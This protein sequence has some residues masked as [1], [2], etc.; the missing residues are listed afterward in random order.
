MTSGPDLSGARGAGRSGDG[1]GLSATGAGTSGDERSDGG[2][3]DID[4]SGIEASG[5]GEAPHRFRVD[6]VRP[7]VALVVMDRADKRNAMDPALFRQLIA[8]MR[9]LDEHP[10]VRACVLTGAGSAFSAGGDIASFADLNGAEA[11]RRQLA[12]VFDAFRS[13]E[14]S[15]VAVVAAVNGL[16][17]AGGLE[18][19]LACDLAVAGEHARFAF[20]EVAVGLMPAFGMLRAPQRIGEGWTRHLVLTGDDVDAT[21]AERIGLVQQVVPDDE[22]VEVALDLAER[23]AAHPPLAV[24]MAK[25]IFTMG[26]EHLDTA[27]REATVVLFGTAD[28][29]SAVERFLAR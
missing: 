3:P 17:Y 18:L 16:A 11:H 25:Q 27:A 5:T 28:H 10:G 29:R 19:V 4:V 26:A 8:V 12:L 7:G 14:R 22:V 2:A 1:A 15:E 21:T 6:M 24:A 20:R 9:A 13:V 23:I